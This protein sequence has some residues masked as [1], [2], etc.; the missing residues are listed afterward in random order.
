MYHEF[1]PGDIETLLL[2]NELKYSLNVYNKMIFDAI[3]ENK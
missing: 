2:N 1:I 3:Q